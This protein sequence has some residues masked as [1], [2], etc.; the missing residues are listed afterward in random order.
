MPVAAFPLADAKLIGQFQKSLPA[1]CNG[2]G[3][4]ACKNVG[5]ISLK[6]AFDSAYAELL[7]AYA[8]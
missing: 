4:E 6:I 1:V 5:I 7:A 8:K 2:E 3:A